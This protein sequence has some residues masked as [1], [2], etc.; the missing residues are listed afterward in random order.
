MT[1][2]RPLSKELAEK[3]QNELNEVPSRI[4]Q[5]LEQIKTWLNKQPYINARLG[6]L[7]MF[8]VYPSAE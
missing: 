6:E 2:I 3:A 1:T 4:P 7:N 8:M 5:D